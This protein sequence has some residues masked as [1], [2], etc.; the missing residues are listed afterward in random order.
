MLVLTR[1]IG[2]AIHI[3]SEIVVTVLDVK[4][5]RVRIGID[6]PLKY[7]IVRQEI[8]RPSP[9]IKA[10]SEQDPLDHPRT[11]SRRSLA[12]QPINPC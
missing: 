4:G 6:A 11:N 10:N 2:E 1:K 9:S 3:D 12:Q 5:G 8:D 7:R